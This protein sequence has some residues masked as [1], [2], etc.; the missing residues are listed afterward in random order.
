M[1]DSD[2]TD[3]RLTQNLTLLGRKATTED[4]RLEVFPAPKSG[5][6]R[7]VTLSTDEIYAH[8]PVTGQPDFYA[9]HLTYWPDRWCVESKSVKLYFQALKDAGI[10]CEH[11]CDKIASDFFE[12]LQPSRIRVELIQRPRGGISIRSVSEIGQ[13]NT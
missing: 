2:F 6:L 5:Q 7:E 4:A 9:C 13:G 3:A 1:N 12:A 8:C 11:L 10:F